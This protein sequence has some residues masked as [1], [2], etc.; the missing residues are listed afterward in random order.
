MLVKEIIEK[1][2]PYHV[3][4]YVLAKLVEDDAYYTRMRGQLSKPFNSLNLAHVI[5]RTNPAID[6]IVIAF[7]G[8]SSPRQL[9]RDKEYATDE[10]YIADLTTA[11]LSDE[12]YVPSQPIEITQ[13]NSFKQMLENL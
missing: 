4:Q 6:V 11:M 7:G 5:S 13:I 9:L 2:F 12:T 3:A 1:V 8:N 10:E